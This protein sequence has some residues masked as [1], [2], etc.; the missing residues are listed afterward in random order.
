MHPTFNLFLTFFISLVLNIIENIVNYRRTHLYQ[1]SLA[2]SVP[3]YQLTVQP[4]A[5][6]CNRLNKFK[7]NFHALNN[8]IINITVTVLSQALIIWNGL[9]QLSELIIWNGLA[10]LSKLKHNLQSC[11]TWCTSQPGMATKLARVSYLFTIWQ[12][13]K[14]FLLQCLNDIIYLIIFETEIPKTQL[15]N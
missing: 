14:T 12:N 3:G 15:Q 7:Y 5:V 10:Q 2:G 1:L 11:V 4:T 6:R 13:C 8:D 9:A